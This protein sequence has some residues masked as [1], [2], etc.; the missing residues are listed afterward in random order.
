MVNMWNIYLD[1]ISSPSAK[2]FSFLNQVWMCIYGTNN[3]MLKWVVFQKPQEFRKRVV[4]SQFNVDYISYSPFLEVNYFV[5][6]GHLFSSIYSNVYPQKRFIIYMTYGIELFEKLPSWN[7][8][9]TKFT[10]KMLLIA[11]IWA[12]CCIPLFTSKEL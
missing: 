12:F 10:L 11:E 7:V 3:K 9:E 1:T 5:L 4:V 2:L 6:W 8:L